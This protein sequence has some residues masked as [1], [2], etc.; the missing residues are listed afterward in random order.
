MPTLQV[1]AAKCLLT[2]LS[3]CP[4]RERPETFHPRTRPLKRQNRNR[5]GLA[6]LELV[7]WLPILLMVAALMVNI[8]TMAAWRVRGEIVARDAAWRGRYPRN[9]QNEPRVPQNVWPADAA[10]AAVGEP[11]IAELDHPALQHPVIRGPLPNR[12]VVNDLLRPDQ[13]AVG[14]M[15]EI[16]RTY[17]LLANTLGQYHSGEIRHPLLDGKFQNHDM[18]I[19]NIYRRTKVLYQLP[20]T[21]PNL[22]QAFVQAVVDLLNIPHYANVRVLDHDPE[23]EEYFGRYVDFHPAI[24]L[25]S[26]LDRQVVYD[27]CVKR[28]VDF[29]ED[30]DGDGDEEIYLMRISR[31]PRT[32]TSFYLSMYRQAVEELQQQIDDWNQETQD[33]NDMLAGLPNERRD[34]TN[35]IADLNRQI[36]IASRSGSASEVSALQSELNSLQ[37]Q[38]RG[39]DSQ[40]QNARDRLAELPGL[41][42]E[43]MAEIQLLEE[44]RI[45]P[46]EQYQDRLP[47]I[48]DQLREAFREYHEGPQIE[49]AE[50]AGVEP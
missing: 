4:L 34:L 37:S 27:V 12:F 13:G 48:E 23:V 33:L 14:G 1:D 36:T 28:I 46:L 26:S 45:Q 10:M 40:A 25:M 9:G 18:G 38:L 11:E 19:P 16:T 7:L 50:D 29:S 39:L 3:N 41:I 30:R 22:P 44:Q 21:A 32:M 6:P 35:S 47:E 8:G 42:S 15:S 24:Q 17:P 43:A 20:Q 31:L 2:K 49:W 5:R